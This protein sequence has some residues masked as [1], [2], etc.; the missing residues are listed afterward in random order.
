[1]RARGPSEPRPHPPQLRPAMPRSRSSAGARS[2][3]YQTTAPTRSRRR[4]GV[5]RSGFAQACRAGIS[6]WN[7]R[8]HIVQFEPRGG[9]GPVR[10]FLKP[11]ASSARYCGLGPALGT[12][13][14]EGERGGLERP[15]LFPFDS[16]SETVSRIRLSVR[17]THP[18]RGAS[19]S[20]RRSS[21]FGC[22]PTVV[23]V[24]LVAS[25]GGGKGGRPSRC[26]NA[27][28]STAAMMAI[29]AIAVRR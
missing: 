15:E 25:P 13:A 28:T 14:S 3:S 20:V 21:M 4:A 22:S 12:L 6:S 24:S 10:S 1:M 29:K 7:P 5:V 27:S 8:A 17:R 2:P 23:S 19:T 11:L 26:F 16:I 18:G 9:C